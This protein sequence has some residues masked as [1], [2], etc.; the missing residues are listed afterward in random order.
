[1]KRTIDVGVAAENRRH[2][3]GGVVPP[4]LLVAI[5]WL[6]APLS[7]AQPAAVQMQCKGTVVSV[8]DGIE[9]KTD[10][11][12][13]DLTFNPQD[14]G[15]EVLGDWGCL[16]D[17]GQPPSSLPALNSKCAGRLAATATDRDI[18]Y[19]AERDTDNVSSNATLRLN[20]YSGSLSTYGATAA[21]PNYG[22]TWG[23]FTTSGSFQCAPL[24]RMF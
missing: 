15:L 7:L 19:Y 3:K 18:L 16:A 22:A 5:L 4:T 11:R 23:L 12:S 20:R 6:S 21:K 17:F 10:Q 14:D 9:K 13:L 8:V 2:R 24:R 1:M